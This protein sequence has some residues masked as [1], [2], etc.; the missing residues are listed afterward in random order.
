MI[1]VIYIVENISEYLNQLGY[2][3]KEFDVTIV[4]GKY[5]LKNNIY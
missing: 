1:D 5:S 4:D 2:Y 3:I